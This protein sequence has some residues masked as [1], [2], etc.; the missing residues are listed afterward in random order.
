MLPIVW[1]LE[2]EKKGMSAQKTSRLFV[3]WECELSSYRKLPDG[4]QINPH[5]LTLLFLGN[6]EQDMLSK[7]V[8]ELPSYQ[9]MIAPCLIADKLIYL[10]PKEM[11]VA[12]LGIQLPDESILG[13]Q[14][15]LRDHFESLGLTFDRRP[16]FPHVSL[17][18]RPFDTKELQQWFIPQP[19]LLKSIH[20]YESV[21][22]LTYKP[23]VSQS[24]LSSFE[25][26][27]HT[28]DLAFS[29]RGMN[30]DE[31]FY[32]SL[33]ALSFTYPPFLTYATRKKVQD[34]SSIIYNLNQYVSIMDREIGSPFKAIS[35]SGSIVEGQKGLLTWEMIVDV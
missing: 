22:E 12:A 1:T 4:R 3:G 25:P 34:L 17:L 26:I 24:I 33:M 9:G 7:V 31:L 10:P 6:V 15:L 29:I 28:A 19:I 20:L 35:Y 16:F 32:N 2:G 30:I 11:R 5:H 23:V 13:Y 21:A 27:E 18:R 14:M 8:A